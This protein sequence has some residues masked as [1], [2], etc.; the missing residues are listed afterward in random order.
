MKLTITRALAELKLLDK[1]IQKE[2]VGINYVDLYRKRHN[3]LKKTQMTV[4]EYEKAVQS[5]MQ[6]LNDLM[7]RRRKMKA[8]LLESNATTIIKVA[9]EKMTVAEA[10]DRKQTIDY[11]KQMVEVMRHQYSYA[12]SQVQE[13]EP[14]LQERVEAM[15]EAN[16]GKDKKVDSD[17]YDKIA[18]PFIEANTLRMVD[19]LKIDKEIKKL[20]EMI[21]E[22][23]SEVDFVLSESNARTE[24]EV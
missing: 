17:D 6:S 14:K 23:E 19:P 22:F 24:I 1:R 21:D 20:D 8:A 10:I 16:L 4:E 7:H 2:I 18:L 11:L 12:L 5:D 13:D 15:L 3:K 9:G